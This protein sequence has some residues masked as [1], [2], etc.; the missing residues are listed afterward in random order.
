MGIRL[1]TGPSAGIGQE[2]GREKGPAPWE[3]LSHTPSPSAGD[4]GGNGPYLNVS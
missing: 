4:G 1:T 3:E 2:R